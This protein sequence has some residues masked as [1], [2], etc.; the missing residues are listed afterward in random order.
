MPAPP[1]DM[2]QTP[3][4]PMDEPPWAPENYIEKGLFSKK[5]AKTKTEENS[6]QAIN[7]MQ[8]YLWF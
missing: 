4:P 6:N 8:R 7:T 5:K 2:Y 1:E 3:P